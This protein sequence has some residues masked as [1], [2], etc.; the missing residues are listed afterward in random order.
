MRRAASI[1]AICQ[2]KDIDRA[3]AV[4]IR[5]VWLEAGRQELLALA[6][7]HGITL[8]HGYAESLNY[9]RALIIDKLAGTHG[10]EHLGEHRRTG[11]DVDYCN[12]GDTYASTIIFHG[13]VMHVACWG[14]YVERGAV[15]E[16]R[17]F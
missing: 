9:L 10:V 15:R 8:H 7:T 16:S 1:K 17:G 5:H 6:E 13:D 11:L 3:T 14:D 12:A 4:I 2:I